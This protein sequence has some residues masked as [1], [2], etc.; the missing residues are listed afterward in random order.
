MNMPITLPGLV[1]QALADADPRPKVLVGESDA[2]LLFAF[3]RVL[4]VAGYRVLIAT[5]GEQ[6]VRTAE[7]SLPDLALLDVQMPHMG[8]LAAAKAMR[9]AE[10]TRD[11]PILLLGAEPGVR[12]DAARLGLEGA[13]IKPFRMEA[14]RE[15]VA[16]AVE[17][18]RLERAG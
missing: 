11:V 14:L 6:A 10:A 5:D 8:G 12:R 9:S 13:I 18:R 3:W 16:R 17:G 2:A 15:Q 1:E 7:R 4:E